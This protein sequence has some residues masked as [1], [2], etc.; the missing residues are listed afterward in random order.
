[1]KLER[2]LSKYSKYFLVIAIIL[3]SV[4]ISIKSGQGRVQLI[5]ENYPVLIFIL[6]L[7]SSFLV[8]IYFHF[9]KM[10]YSELR[11]QIK[12]STHSEDDDFKTLLA[13]LTDRQKEVYD[14]II[15]GKTNKEIMAK[16][17]VEK[18]TLKSHI[19]QIYKKLDIKSR[20]DLK[21]NQRA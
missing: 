19:N 21:S 6:I 13:Q 9:D 12:N 15:A 1:M 5:L 4:A 18:S 3:S 11:A 17:F 20:R 8:L 7:L 10:K 2:V 16:L 14:L